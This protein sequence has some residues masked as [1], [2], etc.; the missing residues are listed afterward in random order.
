MTE[1]INDDALEWPGDAAPQTRYTGHSPVRGREPEQ[2][3]IHDLL[4]G[5]EQGVGGV[6]LVE[7]EPGI[8]K[9]VLL[10]Q[11]MSE[12]EQRGFSVAAASADQLGHTLPFFAL[13]GALGEPFA[14]FMGNGAYRDPSHAPGWWISQMHAYLEKRAAESA[15]LVCLDNLQW[16]D[17]LTLAALRTLLLD[18]KHQPISWL[19]ALTSTPQH[20]AKY[21]FGFLSAHGAARVNLTQLDDQTVASLLAGTFGA[22]P[23]QAL[24]A[25]AGGAAGNPALLTGLIRGWHDDEA[26]LADGE[27]AVLV[28]TRLPPRLVGVAQRRL[29]GL[30]EKTRHLLVT[31]AVLGPSCRLADMAEMIG[32]TPAALLPAVEEAMETAVLTASENAFSFRHEL[33]RGA[34]GQLVPGPARQ[35]LHRQYAQILMRRGDAP[36]LAA[37]QL[38]RAAH[39]EDPASL[40]DLDTAV[41]QTLAS[42]PQTAADLAVRALELTSPADP[43][44]LSRSVA[45]TEA[46]T[47]AGQ[48]DEAA[49]LADAT[50]ANP[51]PPIAEARLRCAL[52]T[53]LCALGQPDKAADQT[54]R[55]LSQGQ[56]PYNLREEALTAH[57]LAHGGQCHDGA[58]GSLG[59]VVLAHP[60]EHE[61]HTIVAAQVLRAQISWNCGQISEALRLL[62]DAARHSTGLALDARRPQPLLPLAAALVDLRQ[63]Q[64]AERIVEASGLS[65]LPAS[66]TQ[67]LLRILRARIDLANGRLAD[68]DDAGQAALAQAHTCGAE[69]YAWMARCVL[70]VIALRRGDVATAAQHLAELPGFVSDPPSWYPR[71]E[72]ALARAQVVEARNGPAAAI[73]HLRQ[74]DPGLTTGRGVLLGDPYVAAWLVRTSLAAGDQTL[75]DQVANA[76]MAL[77]NASPGVVA[78]AAAGA[79]SQGL[80]AGDPVLVAQAV[81]QHPDPWA[82]ASAAEDLAVL[83]TD[84]ARDQAVGHLKSALE[85]YRQM[86]A[87]RDEARVRRRLRALGIRRRHWTTPADRPLAGW[88]SL[89]DTEKAV[90]RLVAE[91]LNNRQIGGR[92]YISTHTVAH[93]LRQAFRKLQ[94]A[95]RVELTRVVMARS[96][97]RRIRVPMP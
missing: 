30:S 96:D 82:R 78:L 75:A 92:M 91:G 71:S 8:G 87:V 1:I 24:L 58:S 53:V 66:P 89:T 13:C 6:V 21:L 43:T 60:D 50:L 94:I 49:R 4:R 46:L 25:V 86:G 14:N 19:L 39:A 9:S 83:L 32:E 18:L 79:H 44:L 55:V 7:G 62:Q 41:A 65:A 29:D 85:G 68:A 80:A 3:I 37:A 95:S 17:P 28:S 61:S 90:A 27:R 88:D 84:S 81:A 47:A 57:L 56:L 11:A 34:V 22:P 26:V 5:A 64:E 45:A 16:A 42:A 10:R 2:R 52:S 76:A 69:G 15:V 73:S 31:A 35:A 40:A 59:D 97:G 12:A 72:T 33:L 20:D 93:H 54:H 36:A 67:A 23:D 70:A 77:A 51:V 74:A 38:L 63:L 48:L